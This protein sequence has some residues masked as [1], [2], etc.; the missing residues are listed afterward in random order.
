M[1]RTRIAKKQAKSDNNHDPVRQRMRQWVD[2]RPGWAIMT[3][4]QGVF[5]T[6]VAKLDGV[7]MASYGDPGDLL[8]RLDSDFS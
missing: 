7:T 4:G 5:R 1:S 3:E 2:G 6:W 8:D